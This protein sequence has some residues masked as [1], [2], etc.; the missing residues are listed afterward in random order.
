MQPQILGE[1]FDQPFVLARPIPARCLLRSPGRPVPI[2]N[3]GS[4]AILLAPDTLLPACGCRR[5]DRDGCFDGGIRPR[6]LDPVPGSVRFRVVVDTE[7]LPKITIDD[8]PR[9]LAEEDE[10]VVGIR[11]PRPSRHV[12]YEEPYAADLVRVLEEDFTFSER[13]LRIPHGLIH[14]PSFEM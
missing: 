8:I 10:R 7:T 12:V 4:E 2:R 13:D 11:T 6:G 5:R 9:A 3:R 1:P 14:W